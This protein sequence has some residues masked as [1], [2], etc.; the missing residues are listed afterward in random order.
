MQPQPLCDV[1][2]LGFSS[3]KKPIVRPVPPTVSILVNGEPVV[4]PATPVRST[5]ANGILSV[6]LYQATH[7]IP[8]TVTDI[9]QV[10]A[11]ASDPMVKV[12]V[13]QAEARDGTAIVKFDHKGMVKT[14]R[15]VLTPQVVLAPQ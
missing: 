1:L 4:L 14:Y 7:S 13:T 10:S 3:D 2:G 11:S 5:N 6:D 12:A 15:V 8:A 9:P